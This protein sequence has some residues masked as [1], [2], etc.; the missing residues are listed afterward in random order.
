MD[1]H[2]KLLSINPAR[3]V[4]FFKS[5][6][7][8]FHTWTKEEVEQYLATHKEGIKARLALSLLLYTGVRRSDVILLGRQMVRDGWIRF[9]P[10]KTRHLTADF[11]EIPALPALAAELALALRTTSTS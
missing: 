4:P 2:D 8:G 7:E 1:E 11:V 10:K 9:Q 5:N 3:D 6:S